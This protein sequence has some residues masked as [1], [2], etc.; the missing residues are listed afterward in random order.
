MLVKTLTQYN[1]YFAWFFFNAR[2]KLMLSCPFMSAVIAENIKSLLLLLDPS[3][4]SM[5]ASGTVVISQCAEVVGGF[6]PK[7]ERST[8]LA[9]SRIMLYTSFSWS[10]S[11]ML[12]WRFFWVLC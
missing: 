12:F 8:R 5:S 6:G 7:I 10:Q 9:A 1:P 4:I 11:V 2:R 3:Q